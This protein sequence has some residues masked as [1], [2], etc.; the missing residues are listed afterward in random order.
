MPKKKTNDQDLIFNNKKETEMKSKKPKIEIDPHDKE[1]NY[2]IDQQFHHLINDLLS[3]KCHPSSIVY[4]GTAKLTEFALLA[5]KGNIPA[6]VLNQFNA[7]C[8][9]LEKIVPQEFQPS[10]FGCKK[11]WQH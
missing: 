5:T 6:G 11:K 9:E 3:K 8:M 10:D 4:T 7:I 1:M 2:E